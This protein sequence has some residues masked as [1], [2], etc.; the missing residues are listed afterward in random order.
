[1]NRQPISH[2]ILRSTTQIHYELNKELMCFSEFFKKKRINN[3]DSFSHIGEI[4]KLTVETRRQ[5]W[6][7]FGG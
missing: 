2:F 3:Q 4:K 7:K 5:S 6:A 1:M